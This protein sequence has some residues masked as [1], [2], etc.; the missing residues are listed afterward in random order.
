MRTSAYGSGGGTQSS[1]QQ[2]IVAKVLPHGTVFARGPLGTDLPAQLLA[3][4]RVLRVLRHHSALCPA[5]LAT[6]LKQ[7][8]VQIACGCGAHRPS[9]PPCL[10]QT[11]EAAAPWLLGCPDVSQQLK[12]SVR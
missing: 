6:P 4:P 12:Y 1:P 9:L 2:R 11:S 5:G 7:S 3:R 8:G 10:R